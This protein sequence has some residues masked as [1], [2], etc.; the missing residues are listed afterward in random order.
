VNAINDVSK[1]TGGL[2][3]G[4]GSGCVRVWLVDG[5]ASEREHFSQLLNQRDGIICTRTFASGAEILA[6]LD[7]ERP[8]DVLL[9]EVT[10]DNDSGLDLIRPIRKLA[11]SAKVLMFTTF[12]NAY[13]ATE[14]LRL[15]ASGFLLKTLDGND[16]ERCIRLAKAG[17]QP[18]APGAGAA[19]P[20]AVV[21]HFFR[22]LGSR[23]AH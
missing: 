1:G 17:H 15:G 10:L 16:L 12:R 7:E 11:P 14:A 8:P 9:L 6:T 23:L 21:S 20:T 4:L 2:P 18:S 5:P 22:A 19:G 13:Y 3:N